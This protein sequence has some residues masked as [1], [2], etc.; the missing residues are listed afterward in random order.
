MG[1]EQEITEQEIK[2]IQ[3]KVMLNDLYRCL[4]LCGHLRMAVLDEIPEGEKGTVIREVDAL[5]ESLFGS[6][7][8]AILRNSL[9]SNYILDFRFRERESSPAAMM[10]ELVGKLAA[11]RGFPQGL[12]EPYRARKDE[13]SVLVGLELRCDSATNYES[14]ASAADWF[15]HG[16]RYYE[17]LY[18]KI[19]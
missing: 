3:A 6:H 19:S 1:Q 4:V 15:C 10:D 17:N 5:A 9:S 16:C 18:R 12:V 2:E 11:D 8:L 7:R 14:I 13:D